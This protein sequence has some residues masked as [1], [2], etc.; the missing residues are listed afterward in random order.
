MKFPRVFKSV[1]QLPYDLSRLIAGCNAIKR[2]GMI[3]AI[4]TGERSA[5]LAGVRPGANLAKRSF[6]FDS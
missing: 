6:D 2:G 4:R 1:N 5:E 3:L